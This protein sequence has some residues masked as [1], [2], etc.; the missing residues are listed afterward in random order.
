ML[1]GEQRGVDEILVS[2]EARYPTDEEE[3]AETEGWRAFDDLPSPGIWIALATF[4]PT[5]LAVVIGVPHVL[6]SALA[7]HATEPRDPVA[8]RSAM[9]AVTAS[10][11]T[12]WPADLRPE[13]LATSVP[14]GTEERG[15]LTTLVDDA[16]TPRPSRETTEFA[17]SPKPTAIRPK[18][19]KPAPAED[20]AW[21]PAAAFADNQ[22]AAR[23]ASMMRNQGYQVDVRHEDSATR[24]WVVRIKANRQNRKA[25]ETRPAPGGSRRQALE[26]G[27]R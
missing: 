25:D 4:I 24:P 17:A 2:L 14:S 12:G 10:S 6:T 3:Q 22:T 20:S 21:A 27:P 19:P 5:F 7:P 11:T 13:F 8:P 16:P 26:N 9:M 1:P 23:L 18:A 15:R